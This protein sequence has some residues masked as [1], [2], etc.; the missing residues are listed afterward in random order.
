LGVFSR[1]FGKERGAPR[2]E[3]VVEYQGGGLSELTDWRGNIYEN[4]IARAA[5]W[6]N[7]KNAG[8]L[9]PKHIRKNGDKFDEFPVPKVKRI[10]E[11]PNPYM[12]MSVFINKMVTQCQ[13]KNNAFALIK[14]DIDGWAEGIYPVSYSRAEAVESGGFY[15]V[16]FYLA[17]GSQMTVPYTELIHLRIHF[18]EKDLFGESNQKAL[19]PIMSVL[20]ETDKGIVN[21]IKKS[22][23]IRWILKFQNV[24]NPEDKQR[25]I[26]DFVKNY[27][28]VE[29]SGGAAGTDPRYEAVPVKPES[30]VPNALQMEKAKERIY[31]YFGVSEIIIQSKF[32]ESDW[33]AY[34]ENTIEPYA[35]QL[36][37]EF[38]EKLF[39]QHERECGNMVIFEANRL[40]YAG[41]K[42][43]IEVAR[44]LADIGAATID[45]LLEIFNMAPLGGEDG[46]RRVQTL[47]MVNAAKADLYQLGEQNGAGPGK[48]GH[49]EGEPEEEPS[50]DGPGK[51][52]PNKEGTGEGK[53]NKAEPGKDA[54]GGK[55]EGE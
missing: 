48:E 34:Y 52:K 27:L 40:Q 55:K 28:S 51:G 25:Q 53:P 41:A 50:N 43:K 19:A 35:I 47:N 31:S 20:Q 17:D 3:T 29:N 33:D 22:A 1:L 54:P 30:Y 11:R 12:S 24:L 10:L 37:E 39:T 14:F 38:T 9:N 44:F 5:V 26:D 7:A 4:D 42:T 2:G 18:D 46:K 13:K 36:S 49:G 6:T 8:K 45:Q 32:N 21:A 15:F 23:V 16:R